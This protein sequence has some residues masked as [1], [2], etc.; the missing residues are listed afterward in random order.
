MPVDPV[1]TEF[2]GKYLKGLALTSGRA[3]S[4][5][6]LVMQGLVRMPQT[7]EFFTQELREPFIP[8]SQNTQEFPKRRHP[9][10]G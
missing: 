6:L 2:V 3:P 7:Q 1:L 5:L 9:S 10:L 8:C 4:W